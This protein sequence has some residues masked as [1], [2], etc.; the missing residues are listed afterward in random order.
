MQHF[1]YVFSNED[2]DTLVG[3]GYRLFQG[4]DLQKVYVFLQDDRIDIAG[5]DI[6]YVISDTLT[7]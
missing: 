1:I 5:A 7:I 6:P 4:D 3:M 2:R